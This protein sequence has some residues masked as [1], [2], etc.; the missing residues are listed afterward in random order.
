MT[1][2]KAIAGDAGLLVEYV[3]GSASEIE[4]L[5]RKDSL[6]VMGRGA[7]IMGDV[8]KGVAQTRGKSGL[9][10]PFIW[11]SRIGA[12]FAGAVEAATPRSYLHLLWRHWLALLLIFEVLAIAGGSLLSAPGVVQFGVTALLVTLG[13][14]L[15]VWSLSQYI[16]KRKWWVIP[17]VLVVLLFAGLVTLAVLELI[18]LGRSNSWIP[19]FGQGVPTPSP[20]GGPSPSP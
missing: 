14:G 15:L 9:G 13:A 3:K 12:L 8:L 2:L 7:H 18:H 5:P 20:T 1:V 4:P 10:L 6:E 11:L 17:V 16:R 19:I